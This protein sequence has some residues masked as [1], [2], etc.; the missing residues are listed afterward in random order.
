MLAEA[1][2]ENLFYS[3]EQNF[4]RVPL[5]IWNGLNPTMTVVAWLEW[6]TSGEGV[7]V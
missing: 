3:A 5:W 6:M 4:I 1:M 2:Y 7:C